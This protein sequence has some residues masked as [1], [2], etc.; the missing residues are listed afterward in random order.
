MKKILLIAALIL[1]L[2]FGALSAA[3]LYLSSL[4]TEEFL[5]HQ[6]EAYLNAR[7]DL[8]KLRISILSGGDLEVEGFALGTRDRA[9][10]L[11]L[12]LTK[13]SPMSNKA[14]SLEKLV[15]DL[16]LFKLFS[17][18]FHLNGFVVY[19][20]KV[21]LNIAK[22]GSNNLSP[23]FRPPSI[24][25][26]KPNPTSDAIPDKKVQK[27]ELAEGE[28]K[29]AKAFRA[30]DIPLAA[31]LAKIG[32]EDAQLDVRIQ[33]TGDRL[34]IENLYCL[35]HDIEIDPKALAKKNQVKLDFR[36]RLAIFTQ[37]KKESARLHFIANGLARPFHKN[38]GILDPELLLKT[39]VVE[40]SYIS[41]LSITEKLRGQAD[42]LQTIGLS[43]SKLSE[44][45]ILSKDVEAQIRMYRSVLTI[46]SDTKFLTQN[47]GLALNKGAWF[48]TTQ[49]RHKMQGEMWLSKKQSQK[50]IEQVER[51]LARSLGISPAEASQLRQ[52]ILVNLVK[53]G[54]IVLPFHSSGA[55]GKP[56]VQ[57]QAKLPSL[58]EIYKK[59]GKNILQSKAKQEL[60]KLKD[61]HG[62]KLKEAA[63]EEAKK[64]FKKLF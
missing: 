38:T 32:L 41:G 2:F 59:Q 7:V 33:A 28:A 54:Q 11:A 37:E 39:K 9:A 31:S 17:G 6:A 63:K 4:V 47:F 10:N 20:A 19:K 34:L 22:D 23:L 30:Q 52:S 49:A 12:P 61:K 13:R 3:S 53:Q 29:P 35:A 25:Q 16:D 5:V 26:G 44:K 62:D 57:L 58:Q 48:H 1:I 42:K 36:M 21:S 60:R 14:L 18:L 40:G 50:N 64:L 46:L 55:L 56:K 51:G 15:L 45:A 8:K 24:V 27:N 43:L